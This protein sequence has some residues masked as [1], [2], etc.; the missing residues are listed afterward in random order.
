M[1]T[2]RVPSGF[3]TMLVMA[4][5]LTLGGF[6]SPASAKQIVVTTLDDIAISP[7]DANSFCGTGTV[8]DL[9]P[10]GPISLREAII[11]ANN[12]PGAD[13]I[14]FAANLSGTIMVN[15]DGPDTGSDPDPLPPLCGG[16]TTITG[17]LTPTGSPA[18]TLDGSALPAIPPIGGLRIL[19]S[20]N[21]I[22]DLRLQHFPL[23]IVIRAGDL[24]NPGTVEHTTVTNAI[25]TESTFSGIVVVTGD[26][27]G[28][29][30]DHT[31]LA[32]NLV[33]QNGGV[34]IEVLANLSS[35]GSYTQLAHTTIAD[36]EIRENGIGI[37]LLVQGDNNRLTDLTFARNTIAANA[38]G[39]IHVVG[40]SDGADG[41]TIEV[42]IRDN[43]LMDN[44]AV[45]S[46]VLAGFNSSHNRVVARLQGN[47]VEGGANGI[48]V[49]GGNGGDTG[50]VSANNEVDVRLEQNTV[51]SLEGT[52]INLF[53]AV[54]SFDEL[55]NA[56]AN[57]NYVRAL[58]RQNVVE[59]NADGVQMFAGG[60]GLASDNTLEVRV[61]N[62]TVCNNG[63]DILGEGGADDNTGS[64]NLLTGTISKNTATVTV[65]D[66]TLGNMATV[67]QSNNVP[68]P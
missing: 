4:Y 45:T 64:G 62:N 15:F 40:G 68:C 51:R 46:L 66:G 31:T 41:N 34:G 42:G 29:R 9:P 32:Y 49:N 20:H 16:Q 17:R 65:T 56:V 44:G 2:K 24:I 5:C 60:P 33:M 67:T 52:G 27:P 54:G 22:Q 28:S 63:T 48:F 13:T 11:A 21:T 55:S 19:S 36:N 43:T 47:T 57:H 8:S 12:T 6:A 38:G 35:A 14:T 37:D 1:H 39:G 26:I 53:G 50:G 10:T 58:I 3:V 59:D 7:F 30:V 18:I 25:V 23:G 61:E